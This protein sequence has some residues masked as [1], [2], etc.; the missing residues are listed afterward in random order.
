MSRLALRARMLLLL[1]PF[2]KLMGNAETSPP[3]REII[4]SAIDAGETQAAAHLLA[5]MWARSPGLATAG[6]VV[7]RFERLRAHLP[8]KQ[9]RLAILRSFTV[10]PMVPVVRA[11]GFLGGID[12]LVDVGGFNTF[13]QEVAERSGPLSRD[14]DTVLLAW[15]TADLAPE[16]WTT[17]ADVSEETVEA[18]LQNAGAEMQSVVTALRAHSNAALLLHLLDAPSRPNLGILDAQQKLG[19]LEAIQTLNAQ[20]RK[21]QRGLRACYVI[22]VDGVHRQVGTN[23]GL[24]H[25]KWASARL[26]YAPRGILALA[27]EWSRFLYPLAGRTSKVLVCDLDNTLWGGVLGEDGVAG[28]RVGPEAGGAPY[29]ALQRAILDVQ[30]RGVLLAIASKNDE[31]EALRALE[32]HPTMLLRPANFSA[33]QV[34]WNDKASSLRAIARELNVGL[35]SL[36]FLDDNPVEREWIR[37]ELPE[38]TVIELL[39]PPSS[40]AGAVL[41]W[42]GFERL[43]LTSEDRGR[44]KMYAAQRLR[45][46]LRAASHSTETFLES[47]GQRIELARVSA[48]NCERVA[49]LT[50][51]TNQF[52]ATTRRYTT[53]DIDRMANSETFEVIA[54]RVVDRF[55][56]NGWVGVAILHF[57]EKTAE[58]D[59]LLLSCRVI[60]REVET[61]I[62]ADLVDRVRARNVRTIVGHVVPTE[63]N[64]PVRDVFEKHGF[65]RSPTDSSEFGTWHLDVEARPVRWPDHIQRLSV[66]D[67]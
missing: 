64:T 4:D 12:L 54:A 13:R 59:T 29:L 11:L 60:G 46:D 7:S 67:L 52:N 38:V 35:D 10:E 25:G 31:A 22:D 45:A 28:I 49:Q 23:D 6:F 43:E 36:V 16:L 58:I 63:K 14:P 48:F 27:K 15:R 44:D 39:G 1:G 17:F 34:H 21:L 41:D 32:A 2:G 53:A 33:L 65:V 9:H 66:E 62:I 40:F 8:L 56:D 26:P 42:A 3:I 37:R 24:D 50:Q 19:Q 20:L 47:L 51:K 55:G 30:R 57:R 18:A 5:T 61:A